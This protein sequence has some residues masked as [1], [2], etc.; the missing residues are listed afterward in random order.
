MG[1]HDK[2]E[3]LFKKYLTTSRKLSFLELLNELELKDIHY[4]KDNQVLSFDSH[5]GLMYS[6]IMDHD[7][8]GDKIYIIGKIFNTTDETRDL[9]LIYILAKSIEDC[10]F[11]FKLYD[12]SVTPSSNVSVV[13]VYSYNNQ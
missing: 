8:K 9:L 1:V 5:Y 10:M 12:R 2:I 11:I 4:L 13:G 7:S 6:G 3:F